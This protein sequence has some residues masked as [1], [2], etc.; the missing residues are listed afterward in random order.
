VEPNEERSKNK[1]RKEER[2]NEGNWWNQR[3]CSISYPLLLHI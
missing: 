2:I 1:K 3:Q